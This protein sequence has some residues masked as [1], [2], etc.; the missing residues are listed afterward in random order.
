MEL[1][2]VLHLESIGEKL[3]DMIDI[4]QVFSFDHQ[5]VNV[6]NDEYLSSGVASNEQG[7]VGLGH[8]KDDLMM[9][10]SYL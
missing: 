8:S 10:L 3:L 5:V 1:L 2:H 7:I 9:I 6:Y 4:A